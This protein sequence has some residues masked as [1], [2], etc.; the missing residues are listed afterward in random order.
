ME[1]LCNYEVRALHMTNP[2]LPLS[3]KVNLGFSQVN[4][5]IL[6]K[7]QKLLL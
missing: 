4:T 5:V 1:K 3:C 6:Q 7:R 2:M